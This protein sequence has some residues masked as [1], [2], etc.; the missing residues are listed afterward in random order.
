VLISLAHIIEED[1][2]LSSINVQLSL[3]HTLRLC[4]QQNRTAWRSVKL[5]IMEWHTT[6]PPTCCCY[7]NDGEYVLCLFSFNAKYCI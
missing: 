4:Q 3:T 6:V 5:L 7:Y 1:R 2:V